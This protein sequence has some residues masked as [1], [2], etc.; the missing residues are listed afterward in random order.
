MLLQVSFWKSLLVAAESRLKPVAMLAH[1]ANYHCN[2][3][4]DVTL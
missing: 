4:V 1:T 2:N 3:N